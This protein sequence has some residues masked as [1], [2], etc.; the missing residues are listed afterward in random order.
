MDSFAAYA[1]S[2]GIC[3]LEVLLF[4]RLKTI[5]NSNEQMR[6]LYAYAANESTL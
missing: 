4:L 2:R 3:P 5:K 1:Y 6:W